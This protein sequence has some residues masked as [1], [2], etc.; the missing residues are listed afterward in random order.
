MYIGMN[1]EM[2]YTSDDLT[3][4]AQGVECE[5]DD[6]GYCPACSSYV[7]AEEVWMTT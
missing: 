3:C 4:E 6:D 5:P 1:G 2:Y 7:D